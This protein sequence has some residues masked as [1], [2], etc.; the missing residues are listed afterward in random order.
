MKSASVPSEPSP[1]PP[2]QPIWQ[3]FY[4]L[5]TWL[6]SEAPTAR[7]DLGATQGYHDAM[8]VLTN[9]RANLRLDD[10]VTHNESWWHRGRK[11]AS[12]WNDESA[13]LLAQQRATFDS[14][15][16][17]AEKRVALDALAIISDPKKWM[18]WCDVRVL[19]RCETLEAALAAANDELR[20]LRLLVYPENI[21]Q[22]KTSESR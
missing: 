19:E 17:A 6:L 5:T 14:E 2:N 16:A 22:D 20:Q 3:Q 7:I 11:L 4:D 9:F 10:S 1:E 21:A 12:S 13:G 8:L 18:R 15:N